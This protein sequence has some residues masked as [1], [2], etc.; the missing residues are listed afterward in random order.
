MKSNLSRQNNTIRHPEIHRI[1]VFP[2][3]DETARAAGDAIIS[4]VKRNPTA[5]ITWAT[6]STQIPIHTYVIGEQKAGRVDFSRTYAFHL[7]E[8]WPCSPDE[9]HSFVKYLQEQLIHPLNIPKDNTFMING[10]AKDPALEA[11]RY[12]RLLSH[13]HLSILG[14]GPSDDPHIGFNPPGTDF[15]VRTH[16]SELTEAIKRRD[17]VERGQKSP[18]QAITQGI[19]NICE[20]DTIFLI[21]Y[22]EKGK[23]LRKAFYDTITTRNP[24]SALRTAGKK[25]TIFIDEEA[26]R[27]LK[28]P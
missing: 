4:L 3:I 28:T 18:D 21:A 23:G 15:S 17:Q 9:S 19:A 8:Y 2:T 24:A 27:Y 16:V 13:I 20:A 26:A 25:V 7:D 14:I 10:K 5:S 22:G 1:L 12:D 6:G 11:K